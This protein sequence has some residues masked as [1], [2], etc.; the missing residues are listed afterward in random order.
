[1]GIIIKQHSGGFFMFVH[2]NELMNIPSFKNIHLI[3]GESGLE[4]KVSWVYILQTPS[5]EDWV[6]GGE[7][8]FVVNNKNVYNILEEAVSHQL[9]GVVVLKSE[10]NESN[11]NEEIIRYAN[12]ENMPLFEMDYHIKLLDITR[13]ISNYIFQK[14]KREDYLERFFYNLLFV[15]KLNNEDIDEYAMHF[16][17]Q[18]GQV[19]FIAVLKYEEDT[20][21]LEQIRLSL[22]L[23]ID[24]SNVILQS[25]IIS[26]YIVILAFVVPEYMNKAKK[27]LKSAFHILYDK[28]SE[29]LCIGIGSTC[30]SLY[31]V[32]QSYYQAMKSLRLCTKEN[33]IIDYH[34]LGFPRLLLNITNEE[35][36]EEYATFTLGKIMNHDKK[37][38]TFF[39]KTLETYILCNGNI[40]KT[41]ANLFIH[42][43]TCIYRME[44]IKELFNL[45]YDDPYIRA[46]ILN[47]LCII[48]YLNMHT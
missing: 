11:I 37:N 42:R 44:K 23:Y 9:A 38:D 15:T 17:Y 43:N 16:G 36:L 5:L 31:D 32:R 40:S 24:D 6:H 8:M 30:H 10:E 22:Q 45:D 33:V 35:N 29:K 26:N 25:I 20:S 47:S 1:M 28:Y 19:C 2:C 39:L 12:K 46:N 21:K 13:D 27:L 3:A 41:A 18:L 34:E 4:R 7:L 14:Q 48:K